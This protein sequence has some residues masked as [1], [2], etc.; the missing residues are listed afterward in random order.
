M[1]MEDERQQKVMMVLIVVYFKD[2]LMP[3]RCSTGAEGV[4]HARDFSRSPFATT[5][6]V[7]GPGILRSLPLTLQRLVFSLSS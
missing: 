6:P 4:M 7:I 5:S 3:N 2:A 1:R